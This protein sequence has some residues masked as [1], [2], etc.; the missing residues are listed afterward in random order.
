M[1]GEVE[2]FRQKLTNLSD[3]EVVRRLD[4]YAFEITLLQRL[5]LARGIKVGIDVV[6]RKEYSEIL[7]T[8]DNR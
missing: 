8:H 6:D 5:A 1:A 2:R 3:A 4:V 7:V